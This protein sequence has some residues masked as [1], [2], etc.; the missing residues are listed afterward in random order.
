MP[1]QSDAQDNKN[2]FVR[3]NWGKD[4]KDL[5]Q[6]DLLAVQKA[7]YKLF[8]EKGIAEILQEVS[9][10]EDFTGKNWT[11]TFHEH[12]IGKPTI[13]PETAL[14]KGLTYNAPLT[15]GV[16]LTNKKTGET[17]DAE[18]FLGDIPQMTVRGTFVVNGIE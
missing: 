17:H 4:Y 10:V 7:S 11:L 5:P 14:Y 6:L 16:T 18:V 9:P 12:K 3:Q 1:K 2:N 13:D 8:Q 15:I